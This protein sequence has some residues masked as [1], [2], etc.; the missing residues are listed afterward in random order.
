MLSSGVTPSVRMSPV[1]ICVGGETRAIGR[2]LADVG[3]AVTLTLLLVPFAVASV[4]SAML[5]VCLPPVCNVTVALAA[6]F[7]NVS[8]GGGTSGSLLASLTVPW[9]WAMLLGSV[10][11][12]L[13]LTD[14]PAMTLPGDA[15]IVKCGSG[16]TLI[17]A[18]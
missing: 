12:I 9:Y 6:P 13:T 2:C 3:K 4:M 8:C 16:I 7:T 5:M 17:D 14:V 11:V 15:V 10:A 1:W 18:V